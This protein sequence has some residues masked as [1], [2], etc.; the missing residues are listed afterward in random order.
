MVQSNYREGVEVEKHYDIDFK[1]GKWTSEIDVED[2][3]TLNYTYYEGDE[4]FLEGISKKT[5]RVWLK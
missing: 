4:S 3:I 1:K 2:F 5:N